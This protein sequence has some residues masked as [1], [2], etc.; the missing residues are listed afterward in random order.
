MKGNETSEVVR[1]RFRTCPNPLQIH[2]YLQT[3]MPPFSA[4]TGSILKSLVPLNISV[5]S[6]NQKY[7]RRVDGTSNIRRSKP[8]PG[9]RRKD[10]LAEQFRK[11]RSSR[12][13][14]RFW[15]FLV[16]S[17]STFPHVHNHVNRSL[18]ERQW[19]VNQPSNMFIS[20]SFLEARTKSFDHKRVIRSFPEE[21]VE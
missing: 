20:K 16:F 5:S 9:G 2:W 1:V 19:T 3:S 21:I 6:R 4:T 14:G 8:L 10:A 11:A 7:C 15:Y 12:L 17:I 18:M 13:L